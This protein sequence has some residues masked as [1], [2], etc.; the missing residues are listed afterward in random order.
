MTF[1]SENIKY[2]QS[3]IKPDNVN[4]S[5]LYEVIFTEIHTVLMSNEYYCYL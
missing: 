3:L 2:F 5:I 4:V 1:R